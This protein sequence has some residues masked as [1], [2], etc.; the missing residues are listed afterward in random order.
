METWHITS[1]VIIIADGKKSTWST[2]EGGSDSR[3]GLGLLSRGELER[4]SEK[5]HQ[6]R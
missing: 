3:D 4:K 6:K 2:H 1:L 5:L